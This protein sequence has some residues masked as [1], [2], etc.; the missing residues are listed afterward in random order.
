MA[1]QAR[2]SA[3]GLAH[4]GSMLIAFS[5][6]PG[7]GKSTIARAL[8]E[9]IGATYLRIDT[10]ENEL[11]RL[12]GAGL[13]EAGAGYIIAYKLAEENLRLGN[14][15]V[16]DAVN[17]VALTRDAWRLIA[18]RCGVGILEVHVAFS[19]AAEHQRRIEAR[20]TGTRAS[21]WP[22]VS[23]RHIDPPS[24]DAV[25][26]DTVSGNADEHA[27]RIELELSARSQTK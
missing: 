24:P 9:R 14:V 27:A 11:L 12:D 15:V 19:D 13:V 10:V 6:L 4:G 17:P 26:I 16:A 18:E 20:P 23:A 5:G 3:P 22:E 25:L 1:P 21:S 7:T 8:A 2:R